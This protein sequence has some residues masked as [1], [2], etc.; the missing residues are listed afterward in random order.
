MGTENGGLALYPMTT[1]QER[2]GM[3]EGTG[4]G[5]PV[6]ETGTGGTSDRKIH[7]AR[8][9]TIEGEAEAG[10]APGTK[11]NTAAGRDPLRGGGAQAL[12][13]GRDAGTIND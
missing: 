8:A 3:V 1:S 5:V 9:E 12:E 11:T 2:D 13:T 6:T 4:V 10:T 7:V